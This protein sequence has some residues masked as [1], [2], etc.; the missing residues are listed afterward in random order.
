MDDP[1]I[2]MEEYVQLE[3]E[4][5]LRN[6]K[7]YNWETAAYGKIRY[8][9]DINDLKFFETKFP[10]IVCSDALKYELELSSEPM[11]SIQRIQFTDMAYRLTWTSQYSVSSNTDTAYRPPVQ[12]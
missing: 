3:T 11:V 2:T 1:N 10:A 7:M 12:F 8:V 4:K 9:D 6:G 5:A